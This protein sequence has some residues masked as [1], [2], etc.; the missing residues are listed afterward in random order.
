MQKNPSKWWD[1]LGYGVVCDPFE[2]GPFFSELSTWYVLIA[3]YLDI[4]LEISFIFHTICNTGQHKSIFW[5]YLRGFV[6]TIFFRRFFALQRQ[7]ET[8][9]WYLHCV[10][11]WSFSRAPKLVYRFACLSNLLFWFELAQTFFS[12]FQKPSS[13]WAPVKSRSDPTFLVNCILLCETELNFN[14]CKRAWLLH[15]RLPSACTRVWAFFTTACKNPVCCTSCT[16]SVGGREPGAKATSG[17][18]FNKT[19]PLSLRSKHPAIL[20]WHK[21]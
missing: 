7:A 1:K 12:N 8:K 3:T 4:R 13:F 20:R 6:K 11:T 10:S 9:G 15:A 5:W 2:N 18:S 21:K 17:K 16:L 19:L 14:L